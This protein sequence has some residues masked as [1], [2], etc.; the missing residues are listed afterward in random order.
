MTPIARAGIVLG[1]SFGGF[2]DGIVFHQ[3]LQWHHMLSAAADPAVRDDTVLN[4]LA[5]GLFHAAA[6]LL[7]LAGLLLLGRS[8]ADLAAPGTGRALGGGMLAGAGLFNLLE[9]MVNHFLLGIHHVR[10]DAADPLPWDLGLLAAG[11]ALLVA[12]G[13]LLRGVSPS[14]RAAGSGRG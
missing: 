8:R 3:V 10:M 11:L 4:T 5:D 14:R 6:W 7:G 13:L 1:L 12:G 2:F 9:G